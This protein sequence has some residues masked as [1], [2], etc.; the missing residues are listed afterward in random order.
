MC[1][2]S[3]L[4]TWW[5]WG[6]GGMRYSLNGVNASWR[7]G[8]RL[9]LVGRSLWRGRANRWRV[10][11]HPRTSP[12]PPISEPL[13]HSLHFV[14]VSIPCRFGIRLKVSHAPQCGIQT[15]LV[16]EKPT[17]AKLSDEAQQYIEVFIPVM[18]VVKFGQLFTFCC[19][20]YRAFF[21]L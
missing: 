13:Q 1:P 10:W 6:E 21:D 17:N 8:K 2:P 19:M 4:L 16:K 5:S 9:R 18:S 20:M 12:T 3:P 7:E 15:V 14:A 11:S